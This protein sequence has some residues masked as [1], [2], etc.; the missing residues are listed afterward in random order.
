[1]CGILK[2]LNITAVIFL[3]EVI[4]HKEFW[5][6]LLYNML[7]QMSNYQDPHSRKKNGNVCVNFI[8]VPVI[9]QQTNMSRYH[10]NV[11]EVHYLL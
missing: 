7:T 4:S 6:N 10:R 3:N 11:F 5:Y 8:L 9:L 2:P 1:M